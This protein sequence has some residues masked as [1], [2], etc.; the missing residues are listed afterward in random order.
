MKAEVNVDGD[1]YEARASD[2]KPCI[3]IPLDDDEDHIADYWEEEWSIS[4]EPGDADNDD[5]PAGIGRDS[6]KGDGFTNYEEYRG[7][8]VMGQWTETSPV[9]KDLFIL[10]EAYHGIG[11]FDKLQL[12]V[13]LIKRGEFDKAAASSTSTAVGRA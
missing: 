11:Y 6:A 4:Q 7:F 1:W 9:F 5:M 2:G 13:H 3:T 12:Q 8:Q 10:D